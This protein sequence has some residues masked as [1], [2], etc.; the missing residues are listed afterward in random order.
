MN[1]VRWFMGDASLHGIGTSLVPASIPA[2]THVPGP[3]WYLC[4]RTVPLFERGEFDALLQRLP[5]DDVKDFCEWFYRTGMRP[6][7]IR[8]LTWADLDQETWT[9]RLHA[10][11]AKSGYGRVI[12]LEGPLKAIIHRRLGVR[13]LACSYIFSRA[14]RQMGDFR[15]A[16]K[17]VCREVG[18]SEK[19]PYD[20]RRTAVRNM[21]RAGVDP[22][23]AMKISG[24]RTRAVFDRYNIIDERNLRDALTKTTTYLESLPDALVVVPLHRA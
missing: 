14:G 2:V 23:V 18:L 21:V 22:S 16:W 17:S 15:K 20:L 12:P 8:S 19:L 10:K 7:E 5:D 1:C 3:N 4:P 24:H 6:G 9:L 13:R 11:D